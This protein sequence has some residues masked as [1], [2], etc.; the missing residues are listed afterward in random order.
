MQE[1][2]AWSQWHSNLRMSSNK[3]TP[4]WL[5]H[6]TWDFQSKWLN[7]WQLIGCVTT[8][9]QHRT[10]WIHWTS[11][12]EMYPNRKTT[13]CTVLMLTDEYAL[14]S[15]LLVYRKT[16]NDQRSMRLAKKQRKN[17]N[18]AQHV[19]SSYALYH[20]NVCRMRCA[21]HWSID[22][23]WWP[24]RRNLAL[25]IISPISPGGLNRWTDIPLLR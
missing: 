23:A 5:Q 7:A 9:H 21:H 10:H 3:C 19:C 2:S 20:D 25:S 6:N 18:I 15:A 24:H 13:K 22:T 16:K 1:Q 11:A 17:L 8:T 12:W 14:T 4:D